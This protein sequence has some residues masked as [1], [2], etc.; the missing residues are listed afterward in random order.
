MKTQIAGSASNY[1]GDILVTITIGGNDLNGHAIKAI[2]G[3][4]ETVR[5]EFST[6][7]DA[8]L[9]E[10]ATPGRLGSGKVYLVLANIY[11]F[12]DGQGDFATVKCGPGA[13]VI[14]GA[15]ITVFNAWNGVTA[16]SLAK[17]GGTLYD[18][19]ANFMGHGYNDMTAATSGTT[20]TA[21]CIHPNTMGHDAIRRSIYEHRD[22]RA[23]PLIP[24]F[25]SVD[26]ARA[27]PVSRIVSAPAAT[28]RGIPV[29]DPSVFRPRERGRT[30]RGGRRDRPQQ[31]D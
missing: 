22:R 8:E 26:R 12:T 25:A 28:D 9:G 6:H 30:T 5:G 29:G 27:C 16:T 24:E 13:N 2:G 15:D 20:A 18:M 10:L 11:D 3:T 7:L 21:S 4:D 1:P 23:A 17:V 14:V 31:V 19:H